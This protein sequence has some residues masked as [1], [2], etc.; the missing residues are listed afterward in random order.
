MSWISLSP[1]HLILLHMVNE[2]TLFL[3]N[4]ALVENLKAQKQVLGYV[5]LRFGFIH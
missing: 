2:A 5:L 1:Q 4:M 3:I